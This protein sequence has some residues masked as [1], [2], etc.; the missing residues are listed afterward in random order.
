MAV[1]Q[2]VIARLSPDLPDGDTSRKLFF[3]ARGYIRYL[4]SRNL[5]IKFQIDV[6]VYIYIYVYTHIINYKILHY[7]YIYM[8]YPIVFH[9]EVLRIISK[10]S[11]IYIYIH[12]N[13]GS[14]SLQGV[15]D[16]L[17]GLFVPRNL[18]INQGKNH[19]SF[20]LEVHSL[21]PEFPVL[22]LKIT[23]FRFFLVSIQKIKL[24]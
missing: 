16:R 8:E 15:R 14:V 18:P 5:G 24:L 19:M 21:H 2:R 6:H 17:G 22:W 7:I 3:V 9:L 20:H 1:H 13:I 12:W 4:P 23:R 11:Y 10:V